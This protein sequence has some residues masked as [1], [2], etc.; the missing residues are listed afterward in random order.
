MGDA[1]EE[2]EN[3]LKWRL[4]VHRLHTATTRTGPHR[5][6]SRRDRPPAAI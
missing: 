1:G 5:N 2:P 3:L 6:P 4:H